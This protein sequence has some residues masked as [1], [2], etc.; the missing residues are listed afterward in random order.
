MKKKSLMIIG[1]IVLFI[2]LFIGSFIIPVKEEKVW[3]ADDPVV[4]IGHYEIHVKNIYGY[5]L[6]EKK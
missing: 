3:I 1:I 6:E 2:I 4:D 5:V